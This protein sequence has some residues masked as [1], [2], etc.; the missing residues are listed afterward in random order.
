MVGTAIVVALPVTVEAAD[1]SINLSSNV[2]GYCSFD[3][4]PT[5][6]AATNVSPSAL[7]PTSSLVTI[8]TPTDALGIMQF[9]KF[10]L[11]IDG[12]CNVVGDLRLSSEKGGL[13][14]PAHGVGPPPTGFIKRFDYFASVDFDGAG[15]VSI[16]AT[17]GSPISSSP[18]PEYTTGPFS[19]VATLHVTGVQNTSGPLL[20]GSYTDVLTISLIPQ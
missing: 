6:P 8:A 11:K 18:S 13:K 14:D 19:G 16:P 15:P 7:T 17:S 20:A 9:W 5:F 12:T 3:A 10:T 2:I 4:A 1:S